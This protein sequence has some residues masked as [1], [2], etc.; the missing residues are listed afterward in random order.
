MRLALAVLA[1]LLCSTP[2]RAQEAT[3]IV[4][5]AGVAP[6]KFED[7]AGLPAGI[8][9]DIW[10]LW[11]EKTGRAIQFLRTE[12]FNESLE[13]VK[14]GRA[15][16]N[17]GLFR[18]PE[19]EAFLEFSD[20]VFTLNYFVF[21][22][23]SIKMA[24]SLYELQGMVVGVPQGGFTRDL[25]SISIPA[26]LI[27]EYPSN[28]A[29]FQAALRGEIKAFVSTELA[30]LYFLDQNRLA[31][32]FGYDKAAPLSSQTYCA[33]A[34]KGDTARIAEVNAGLARISEA[35]RAALL[36]RW[37]VSGVKTIPPALAGMLTVEER[38][39]LARKRV[40]TVHNESDWAPFNFQE[41]GAPRGFSIDY[42]RLLAEKTGLEVEFISGFSWD[43]YQE[44]L[45]AGQL[46]VMMNIVITPDRSEY[47]TFTPSY[48][49]MA[50]MLYTRKDEPHMGAIADLFGK[51]FAVPKGFYYQELLAAYPEIEIVEVRDTTEAVLA[52]SS[53]RADLL[54]APMP[55]V[56]YLSEQLQVTNLEVGGMVPE[57]DPGPTP[58]GAVPLHMAISRNQAM[59]AE[60][61]T[62]GM[63]LITPAE[64]AA[65]KAA[66]LTPRAGEAAEP[67]LRFTPAQEAWLRAHPSFRM[68]A[69]TDWPPFEL[70]TATGTY[71][72]VI[73]EYV[74]WLQ[75]ALSI[76]MQPVSGMLW[77]EALQAARDGRIDILPAVTPN[78]ERR[79]F[80]HFT[81]PYLTL[82]IVIATRDDADY[83]DSLERLAGKPLAVVRDHIVQHYLERDHP[84]I[85]L[86]LTDTSE[87]AVRAV[88]DGRAFALVENGAVLHY[89][90][91][92]L[93]LKNLKV[94][95]P[96][97]YTYELAMAVRQDLPEL[98][99]ILDQALAAVPETDRTVFYERWINVH[100]ERT[101]DWTAVR[102]VG[103]TLAVFVGGI[104]VA[105]F[106]W[107]RRLAREVAVRTRAEEALRDAEARSRLVLE[108]AGEGIFGMDANG[109][110]LFINTAAC[111]MLGL[112]HDDAIGQDVHALIHHSHADGT[113]YPREQSPMH[114]SCTQSVVHRIE[115]EVLWRADGTSFPAEYT[116]APLRKGEDIAGA[117]VTFRNI[118][119]R[120]A[121]RRALAEKQNFLQSVIDNSSALIYVKDLQG[122]YILGNQT[123]RRTSAAAFAEPIGLTDADLF[124]EA[125]ARQ[126]QENDRTVIESLRPHSWEEI[127]TN[128]QGERIDYYSIK[129]PLLDADGKPYA[130]CGM[131]TDITE[132]KKTEAALQESEKRHRVIFEKSP[133]G[134]ILFSKD[135]TIM[136]CND[137]FVE[138]MGSPRE[139][140]IGFNTARQSTP[141]MRATLRRALDGEATVFEDEYTSV[142]GGRTMVLRA[143]FN[144]INPNTRPTGVIATVEDITERRRIEQQ[145]RSNF[146]ELERFNRLVVGREERMIQLKQEINTLLAAQGL[147]GKYNI[148]Q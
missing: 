71:G 90:E 110:L 104:L 13:M 124:P 134:M 143:S 34:R 130:V 33:A 81:R 126:L 63:T 148:V 106:I 44:M 26:H 50:R 86:L 127:V 35:E 70:T 29:L 12:T 137:K 119:E 18:T 93:G 38:E 144:P 118:T 53:G 97:P 83:V 138:L 7:A 8:L 109:A 65:L 27:R 113:P 100:F 128:S 9:P 15:A 19:R 56:N 54:L 16:L 131:S 139:K 41:N 85:P 57:L 103:L 91:R 30:L 36:Q 60:I 47:M 59:L 94:A 145:L 105:V 11:A 89:L 31:N 129:F 114:R 92:R 45:R 17:A 25:V 58:G 21:T 6:L 88:V 66:W 32:T 75:Q 43:Q 115:N 10:R 73:P 3:S 133:L 96:T 74:Q 125:L 2:A 1:L 111:E 121:T 112:D 39:F 37:L 64:V 78:D 99:A 120:L 48:V 101:V 28:E 76:T 79:A 135:G 147:A 4:Y 146:E 123:W 23:P 132:R 80:L 52:V 122:R 141:N 55:V 142:T 102:R 62:K 136:D 95:G 82:P 49:D 87:E 51:R 61:L 140:L 72:G 20:P 42:I 40:L 69:S 108:S 24:T 68:A 22:H 5:N 14:D 84:D 117:V 98:A 116:T 46:D 77:P 67:Q 107:N